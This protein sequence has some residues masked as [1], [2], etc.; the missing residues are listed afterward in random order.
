[1][2]APD[3]LL[4]IVYRHALATPAREAFRF[5][6]GRHDEQERLTYAQLWA[7]ARGLANELRDRVPA[8]ARVPLV[9]APGL[10]FI[11]ALLACWMLRATAVPLAPETFRRDREDRY[12]LLRRLGA[13]CVLCDERTAL[14][15][16]DGSPIVWL[17]VP[18]LRRATFDAS[19]L[20]ATLDPEDVA[21][22]Q[23]TSGSTSAP[24]GVVITHGNLI[25]NMEMIRDG[26][27][28]DRDSVVA[29]WAPLYH[30]QGLIGNVLQP[31]YLGAR[32][33]L[34]PPQAFVRDPLLWLQLISDHRVHT[35]GGPNFAYDLCA[36]RCNP[37]RLSGV[38]LRSWRVAFNGAEP[39]QAE[40]LQRFSA[41]FAPYGFDPSAMF[42]CYGLAEATLLA[43]GGPARRVPV[44]KAV[45][46]NVRIGCG[47]APRGTEIRIVDPE[48]RKACG[49]DQVGE[50]W[51]AGPHVSRGYWDEA[52]TAGRFSGFL[53][54]GDL[55]CL[56]ES[57]E[58]FPTG[59]L[60]I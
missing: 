43:S 12:G 30:D 26:F 7:E 59:R 57:G 37:A 28:H 42:P 50:I 29:A 13:P 27:G 3:S 39:V 8:G 53:R 16:A 4:E 15:A 60:K 33:V 51:L 36:A 25:A 19:A 10:D 49:P 17:P 9:F 21:L 6:T 48:T 11:V 24:R 38:D 22:L 40:T 55:G 54:T 45:A 41:C 56:D 23:F 2:K 52:A 35:S 32:C 44:E 34:F 46:S 5:L 58:L 1:M 20:P 47:R 18:R 14:L 31:L